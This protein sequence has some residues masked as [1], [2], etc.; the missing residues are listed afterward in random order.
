M[1]LNN[2]GIGVGREQGIQ[3]KQMRGC[4]QHPALRCPPRLQILQESFVERIGGTKMLLFEPCPIAW[5]EVREGK[6]KAQKAVRMRDDAFLGQVGS[7]LMYT[8]Q[9]WCHKVET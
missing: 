4:L 5:H 6:G 9:P 2:A 3:S 1:G 8:T 7:Q